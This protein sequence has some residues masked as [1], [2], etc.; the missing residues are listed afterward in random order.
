MK[1]GR[2]F[3]RPFFN[4]LHLQVEETTENTEGFSRISNNAIPY[5]FSTM[6]LAFDAEAIGIPL[7]RA[8]P[9]FYGLK[10]RIVNWTLLIVN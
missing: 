2:H 7:F 5:G 6:P 1:R 4:C 3:R 10:M 9:G 8:L